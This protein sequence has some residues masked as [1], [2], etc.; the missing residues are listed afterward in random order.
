VKRHGQPLQVAEQFL[1]DVGLQTQRGARHRV[2]PREE[3]D[4]FGNAEQQRD[5]SQRP[6]AGG[7]V[8]SDRTVDNSPRDEGNQGLRQH[9]AAGRDDHEGDRATV[10]TGPAAQAQQGFDRPGVAFHRGPIHIASRYVAG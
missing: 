5:S 4:R 8:R 9:R 7:V 10:R 3:Q 2:S 1:P 6:D